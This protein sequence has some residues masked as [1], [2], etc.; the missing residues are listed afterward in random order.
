M[1]TVWLMTDPR[2][3]DADL[4]R[5]VHRLPHGAAIV[6]RHYDLDEA[7]RRALFEEIRKVAGHR[8]R[9]LVAGDPEQARAWG[10]DGHHG[11]R[12]ARRGKPWLHSAPV[13]DHRELVAAIRAGADAVL[14]SPLFA[15]RSHPGVQPLR[16][17]RF[18]NLARRSS[19]PVIAL[20][21]VHPR[22]A[23]LVRRLGA[24]GF[25]A[26]DGLVARR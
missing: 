25:A 15:T 24:A 9:L 4:L 18:A 6:L 22:H 8:C 2:I 1:P 20:G 21:G 11:R 19:V 23:S 26:I 10:A 14:I 7:D 17:A 3:A 16:A 5:A 12:P 13:H